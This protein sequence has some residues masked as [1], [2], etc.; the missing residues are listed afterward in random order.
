MSPRVI[1]AIGFGSEGFS[2]SIRALERP[3]IAVNSHVD[4][5]VRLLIECLV[6]S[7]KCTL[8]GLEPPYVFPQMII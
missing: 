5:K 6:A 8:I 4:I 3:M 7:W 1:L 2:T